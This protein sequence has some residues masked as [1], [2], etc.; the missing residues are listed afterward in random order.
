MAEELDMMSAKLMVKNI[1]RPQ[2]K[3]T[4]KLLFCPR[5]SLSRIVDKSQFKNHS[6]IPKVHKNEIFWKKS[7]RHGCGS[8]PPEYQSKR[9]TC[10]VKLWR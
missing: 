3:Q 4:F 5:L 6:N 10:T 2:V 7:E 8:R 1:H 9:R